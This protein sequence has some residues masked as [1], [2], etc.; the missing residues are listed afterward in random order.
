MKHTESY[1]TADTTL[2]VADD[3]LFSDQDEREC[4]ICMEQFEEGDVVSWSSYEACSHTYHHQCIKEWLLR[5]NNCPFCREIFLPVDNVHTKITMKVFKELSD[6]RARRAEKTYYCIQDG[7]VTLADKCYSTACARKTSSSSNFTT[8]QPSILR[9]CAHISRS[10]DAVQLKEKLKAG[11]TKADLK[12]LRGNRCDKICYD[13]GPVRDIIQ[14]QEMPS[15]GDN[16]VIQS[17]TSLAVPLGGG[18]DDDGPRILGEPADGASLDRE[19]SSLTVSSHGRASSI[20]F[21]SGALESPTRKDNSVF[22]C[23]ISPIDT[24]CET[25][26]E[27]D[28]SD[29]ATDNEETNSHATIEQPC[30]DILVEET[31]KDKPSEI[32]SEESDRPKRGEKGDSGDNPEKALPT[33]TDSS[34]A[35]N[36]SKDTVTITSSEDTAERDKVLHENVIEEKTRS[37]NFDDSRHSTMQESAAHE[38]FPEKEAKEEGSTFRQEDLI[39][40]HLKE[41]AQGSSSEDE[42]ITLEADEEIAA[43]SIC[44]DDVSHTNATSDAYNN[45]YDEPELSQRTLPLLPSF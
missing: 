41:E 22:D 29:G 1:D 34:C 28:D 10:T 3:N 21:E 40:G 11:V 5:H 2:V 16:V 4:P 30:N 45:V 27:I 32:Q 44:I 35:Q 26:D 25:D 18:T 9:K 13:D 42:Q 17:N 19:D 39:D 24:V 43:Q 38:P 8:T 6:L 14:D 7:L 36:S 12:K 20:D 37:R 23:P 31:D 33:T 15:N